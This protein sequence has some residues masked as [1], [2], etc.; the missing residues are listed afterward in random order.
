MFYEWIMSSTTKEVIINEERISWKTYKVTRGNKFCLMEK[1][2]NV[3]NVQNY[4]EIEKNI[5]CKTGST[6]EVEIQ[7]TN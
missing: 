5:D 7:S 4:W 1:Y 6:T 3:K 2:Q